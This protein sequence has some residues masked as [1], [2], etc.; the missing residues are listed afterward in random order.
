MSRCKP[1]PAS[2]LSHVIIAA[3]QH[4]RKHIL[5]VLRW[6]DEGF[7]VVVHLP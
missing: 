7:I 6:E 4:R 2:T 1:E 3:M 5:P